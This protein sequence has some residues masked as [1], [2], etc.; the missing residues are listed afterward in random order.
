MARLRVGPLPRAW[1]LPTRRASEG[2]APANPMGGPTNTA[3]LSC[4]P[5]RYTFFK[6]FPL[7]FFFSVAMSIATRHRNTPVPHTSEGRGPRGAHLSRLEMRADLP[8][9]AEA[10]EIR[11]GHKAQ[12]VPHHRKGPSRARA[13]GQGGGGGTQWGRAGERHRIHRAR[14]PAVGWRTGEAVGAQQ[15]HAAGGSIPRGGGAGGG[16][17]AVSQE[18]P[19]LR[20]PE[21]QTPRHFSEMSEHIA[22]RWQRWRMRNS[23]R[24][25]L[26]PA[27]LSGCTDQ[28]SCRHP[29]ECRRNTAHEAPPLQHFCD[30]RGKPIIIHHILRHGTRAHVCPCKPLKTPHKLRTECVTQN[31]NPCPPPPNG[32]TSA[33]GVWRQRSTAAAGPTSGVCWREEGWSRRPR[34]QEIRGGKR[35]PQ[36]TTAAGVCGVQSGCHSTAV[37]G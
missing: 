7:S 15:C 35:T 26:C 32:R 10:T 18:N 27:G 17:Y 5:C 28:P 22:R 19:N 33:V 13:G 6:R 14:A 8:C 31:F 1:S 2:V 9:G 24:P 36:N 29:L 37:Q 23:G 12:G 21:G 11:C 34:G 25:L 16:G 4:R 3:G 30:F 20:I